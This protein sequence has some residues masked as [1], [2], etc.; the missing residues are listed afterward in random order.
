MAYQYEEA[1]YTNWDK[2]P[3]VMPLIKNIMYLT[4]GKEE[5]DS[6]SLRS[7]ILSKYNLFFNITL[8]AYLLVT[9]FSIN[10]LI[11]ARRK[12]AAAKVKGLFRRED[13]A[14]PVQTVA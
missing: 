4:M 10:V 8:G 2:V 3:L 6:Y 1:R 11:K 5:T 14:L 7:L 12:T 9:L 13:A